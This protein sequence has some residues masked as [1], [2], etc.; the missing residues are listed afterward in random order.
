MVIAQSNPNMD[1]SELAKLYLYLETL[2]D[3]ADNG[4][5]QFIIVPSDS[6]YILNIP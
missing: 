1:A 5:S 3:I 2:R 4:K 6:P